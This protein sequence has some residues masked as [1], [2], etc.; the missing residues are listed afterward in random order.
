[1]DAM[2]E[3]CYGAAI[4]PLDF[5]FGSAQTA[6]IIEEKKKRELFAAKLIGLLVWH[7]L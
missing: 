1:M 5:V 3:A 6:K 7:V 4:Q 2:Y